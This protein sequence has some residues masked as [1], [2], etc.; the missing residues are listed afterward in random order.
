MGNSKAKG[1]AFEREIAKRLTFWLTGQSKE[2]CFWRSS[3]SGGTFTTNKGA[4]REMSGDLSGLTADAMKICDLINFE[5]KT[6]YDSADLNLFLKENKNEVLKNFWEQSCRDAKL[7]NKEPL[8]IFRKKRMSN[9]WLGLSVN[10]FQRFPILK[11]YRFIMLSWG[12]ECSLPAVVLLNFENFLQ[13][14]TPEKLLQA[15]K[16]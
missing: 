6:G 5:L 3:N 13:E 8:V 16:P 4:T 1:S 10:L 11:N 14:V 9:I 7:T 15:L 12:S 2:M